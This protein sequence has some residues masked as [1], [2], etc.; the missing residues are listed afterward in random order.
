[1]SS[2]RV[3]AAKKTAQLLRLEA[4]EKG[5]KL[6]KDGNSK[7][8]GSANSDGETLN[9]GFYAKQPLQRV[10]QER[11]EKMLGARTAYATALE[12]LEVAEITGEGLEAAQEA[13]TIAGMVVTNMQMA[14][15]APGMVS[16]SNASGSK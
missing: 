7:Y 13:A 4:K 16:L 6:D 1:M 10:K 14:I 11:A 12:D 3:Q 5:S 15:S 2:K 9:E 8:A